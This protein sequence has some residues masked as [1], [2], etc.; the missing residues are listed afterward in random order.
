MK[1]NILF[2]TLIM[3]MLAGGIFIGGA[4]VSSSTAEA[5]CRRVRYC[6]TSYRYV[7]RRSCSYRTRCAQVGGGGYSNGSAYAYRGTACRRS[8]YCVYRSVRIPYRRCSYRTKCYRRRVYR[9][10]YR[11]TYRR[12]YHYRYR[13]T[14][15]Y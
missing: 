2:S 15:N 14:W 1:Q 3:G 8:P 7:R 13:R 6:Y 10:R 12:S 4:V 5:Y 9:R 11:R